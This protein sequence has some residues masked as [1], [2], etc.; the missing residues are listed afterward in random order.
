ME[1]IGKS[2]HLPFPN[3]QTILG[4]GGLS[5][6]KDTQIWSAP[7]ENIPGYSLDDQFPLVSVPRIYNMKLDFDEGSI[8]FVGVTFVEPPDG[9]KLEGIATRTTAGEGASSNKEF[10]LVSETNSRLVKTAAFFSK[11]FGAPD[12]STFD[13]ETLAPSRLLKVDGRTGAILEEANIPDFA[14]WDRNHSWDYTQ[15]VGDRPFQ[16]MHAITIVPSDGEYDDNIIVGFQSALYQDGPTS[17]DFQ[18]SATRFLVFGLN[19]CD[20]SSSTSTP[21]FLHSYRYDTS[22]LT[23]KS[24]QKG[25]RHFNGLLGVLALDST[26]LLV[27][28]CEDFWGFGSEGNKMV[29]RIFYVELDTDK[30]VDHCFSLLDCDVSAPVKRLIWERHDDKQLDGIAWGPVI[31]DANEQYRPTIALT[32]DDDDRLGVHFE[33]YTLNVDELQSSELWPEVASKD[34]LLRKR[35]IAILVS[36]VVVFLLVLFQLVWIRRINLESQAKRIV[37]STPAALE[38]QLKDSRRFS[39]SHYALITAMLNSFLVGGVTFG[40]SGML[41]I[42]RKEGTYAKSC[43][44]GSFCAQEKEHLAL[45]STIGFAVAIGSRICVG[46]FLD[47]RG[48]KAT[49]TICCTSCLSG[50]IVLASTK[51]ENLSDTFMPAWILLSLGGSGLHISGFHFTNLFKND[52]KKIASAAIS[53]AYG[54][55]SAVFPMMQV[56]NQYAG[57]ELQQMAIFYSVVVFFVLMNNFLIQ[58]WKK[59]VPGIP[60]KPDFKFW[61][62][63]WWKI[64]MK[65]KPLL[66]SVFQQMTKFEMWGETLFFSIGLLL[67]T[68][69][70][71]TSAQLMYEKGDQPFSSNPNDW[72]DYMFS[73]MSGWFNSLG[74]LWFPLV[75]LMVTNLRW[76]SSYLILAIINLAVV[77]IVVT[78]SLELQVFGFMLMSMARLMLFSFHHAYIL[79][80][81]GIEHFGTLNGISSLIAA[82]IGLSSYPLQLFALTKNYAISFIPIAGGLILSLAFPLIL[83]RRLMLNWAESVAVDPRKFRYPKDLNELVALVKGPHKIRCAGAMHSCAPLIASEGIIISFQ[84]FDRI[85]EINLD[86]MTAKVQ[87]G[88]RIHELCEALAPHGLALGTLGT[89][90]WQTIAGAVMTGTH[91]GS[92]TVQS[93]H[94]FINSYTIVKSDGAIFQVSRESDPVLFSAIAPSMGVFGV[95]VELEVQCVPLQYLEARLEA[96]PF[97]DLTNRFE[98]IMRT[99]KYTRVVV[100]PSIMQATVWTAN[101]VN[102]GEAVARGAVKSRGYINFRDENEKAWLEQF[103]LLSDKKKYSKADKFLHKVLK[104]QLKRLNHYEGQYNHVLCKERNN[105]IP[106]A[107]IEFNFDFDKHKQV[108]DAVKG[109]CDSNRMP[110]YNFEIRAT[111]RDDAMMSCCYGRDSMWIDFQAKAV[112]GRKFFGVMEALLKPIGFRKHWAKGMDNTNPKYVLEQFP[113]AKEFIMLM[114][115]FDPEGK[116]RNKEGSS[117]YRSMAQELLKAENSSKNEEELD[118][119]LRLSD[120][121][122]D[123]TIHP[124]TPVS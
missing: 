22:H 52:A 13:P 20:S 16:G 69:F 26:T 90:D 75:Q 63:Q 122:D 41:L 64:E 15:C 118:V 93:M 89:I 36:I 72:T 57:L 44:C 102:K 71:S 60:F 27:A 114:R 8:E 37:T 18:N 4:I 59:V 101:P 84:H 77:A 17:S 14:S 46:M 53:A 39:Y 106:H 45:I 98:D 42:L 120:A 48:P 111:Q 103:V 73:R 124:G 112:V 31:Q 9:L 110:Y 87:A 56:L 62:A 35:V 109:Y 43:N 123:P 95:V 78:N 12:L 58:P 29:N 70:L 2:I 115:A 79:D 91:G 121:S 117:W 50:F 34:D 105:G 11:D 113:K 116:F 65:K 1:S 108:L 24:L 100:Y 25:A 7:S 54:A 96:V 51:K 30:T 92:L 23:I 68:H 38:D 104:S 83:R 6:D 88:V 28:E 10:W 33:L 94:T 119:T 55:S 86:R 99:N 82:I 5:Y 85:L 74:F 67:L 107:D 66:A 76:S 19:S 81:F 40:F 97:G 61:R 3:D 80:T 32:F 21:K 47:A 49:A